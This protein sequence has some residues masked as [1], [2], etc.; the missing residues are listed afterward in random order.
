M[1]ISRR[2]VLHLGQAWLAGTAFSGS[3][4]AGDSSAG[5]T[6][7]MS[8]QTFNAVLGTTFTAN[9]N[10]LTPTWLTL[11]TIEDLSGSQMTTQTISTAIT[12]QAFA[13]HF[14]MTG[15]ALS[16]ETY[17]F[18][19]LTLGKISLF[20]VPGNGAAVAVINQLMNPLPAS[21]SI[22][23]PASKKP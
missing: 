18:D 23:Q 14:T 16:Q 1:Q 3:M 5:S 10:S 19:H 21:Y 2:H 22:P 11:A 17:E 8:R 6:P 13:L 20:V 12:T 4:F 9:A 7:P 15:A